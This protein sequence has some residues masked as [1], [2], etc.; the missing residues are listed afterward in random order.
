MPKNDAQIEINRPPEAV[1]PL[2]LG[3]NV[4]RW[5][6]GL[7]RFERLSGA[8]DQVGATFKHHYV[9]RGVE[10]ITLEGEITAI[11]SPSFLK[12]TTTTRDDKGR[13][14]DTYVTYNLQDLGG[15]TRLEYLSETKYYG[16][17]IKLMAPI[18]GIM[19]Q[20]QLKKDLQKLKELVEAPEKVTA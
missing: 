5:V 4:T 17:F 19:A 6:F 2:L 7:G 18:V 3:D 12:M 16:W 1:F 14:F 10:Q 20:R 9:N 8:N 15:K 11:K 13:G